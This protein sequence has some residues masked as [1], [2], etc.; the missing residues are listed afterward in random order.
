M[1]RPDRLLIIN[2]HK[3]LLE[4]RRTKKNLN[5]NALSLS[6]T[7]T[8]SLSI[9]LPLYSCLYLSLSHT[10]S[11]SLT[12]SHTKYF[13]ICLSIYLSACLYQSPLYLS[14]CYSPCLPPL[15]P[16][17]CLSVVCIIPLYLYMFV[18]P[19]SCLPPLCLSVCSMY[20]SPL[21]PSVWWSLCLVF[22]NPLCLFFCSLYH[23]PLCL[24][25]FVMPSI[26]LLFIHLFVCP[27]FSLSLSD[28]HCV[29]FFFNHRH[30]P[31]LKHKHAKSH[32]LSLFCSFLS[33][34]Q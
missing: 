10:H 11:L 17:V 28:T 5:V 6:H 26:F 31:K 21:Y 4:V 34:L 30:V 24:Y 25:L 2:S 19:L 16:S 27:S 33:S 20:H 29:L 23:S 32:Y 7:H 1:R 22:R 8:H 14:V 9:C 18:L 12:Y 15:C 3:G 13:S